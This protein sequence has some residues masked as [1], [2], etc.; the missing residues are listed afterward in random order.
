MCR[1]RLAGGG[2]E[3]F[4]QGLPL[5]LMGRAAVFAG[6]AAVPVA[7]VGGVALLAME[8]GVDGHGVVGF[9]VVDEAVGARPVAFRIPPESFERRR[10]PGGRSVVGERAGEGGEVHGELLVASC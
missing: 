2:E 8:V 9:Q 5:G 7:G 6:G 4:E 10:K 1:C 3:G